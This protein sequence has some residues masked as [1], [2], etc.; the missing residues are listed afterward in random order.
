MHCHS[1]VDKR[2]ELSCFGNGR[3]GCAARGAGHALSSRTSSGHARGRQRD[4][5]R[6]PARPPHQGR[7]TTIFF[8]VVC[9]SSYGTVATEAVESRFGV[10]RSRRGA[11]HGLQW[12]NV[13]ASRIPWRTKRLERD[14]QPVDTSITASNNLPDGRFWWLARAPVARTCR[15]RQIGLGRVVVLFCQ[16]KVES[17]VYLS[18]VVTLITVQAIPCHYQSKLE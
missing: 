13:D 15:L 7:M 10:D 17:N 11:G 4:K 18:Q 2:A 14:S 6:R 16:R 1:D 8:G 9:N 12:S 5:N 3:C